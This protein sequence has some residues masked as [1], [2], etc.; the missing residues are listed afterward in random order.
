[1]RGS[2]NRENPTGYKVVRIRYNE[3][4]QPEEFEDFVTGFLLEDGRSHFG[5]LVGLTMHTDGSLLFTDDSNG[6]VYRVSYEGNN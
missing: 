3:D 1:M 6:V 4:G 2:W 5:R